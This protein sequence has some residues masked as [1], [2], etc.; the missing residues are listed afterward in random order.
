MAHRPRKLTPQSSQRNQS[1]ANGKKPVSSKIRE[2]PQKRGWLWSTLA[3]ALL[4]SS[5]GL[6]VG[7]IW[8][9]IL[10][11]FN[12]EQLEW[13]NEFLPAWV[14]IPVLNSD[15]P[16]SRKQIQDNLS[17]QQMAGRFLALDAEESSFL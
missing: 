14:Q 4:L 10:F 12:P 13:V 3:I 9:S 1:Q 8:M 11:I 16:Q 17:K 6:I 15:R 2:T 5:A 7:F